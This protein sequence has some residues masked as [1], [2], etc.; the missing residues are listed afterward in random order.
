MVPLSGST[1]RFLPMEVDLMLL[2]LSNSLIIGYCMTYF[3]S[4]KTQ[5]YPVV[6]L[7][8]LTLGYN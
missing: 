3:L 7:T 5:T 2:S 1:I 4:V 8:Y 6:N